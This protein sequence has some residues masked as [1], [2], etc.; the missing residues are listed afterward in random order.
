MNVGRGPRCVI[1]GN[2]EPGRNSNALSG[3]GAT[4]GAT[5][6]RLDA[7]E[8]SIGTIGKPCALLRTVALLRPRVQRKFYLHEC[9][10]AVYNLKGKRPRRWARLSMPRSR[11]SMP[12]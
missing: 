8:T 9:Q 4:R 1:E 7:F 2:D 10:A 5:R 12:K 6:G 11:R 3:R